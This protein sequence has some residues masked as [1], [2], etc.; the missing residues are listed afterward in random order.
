MDSIDADQVVATVDSP[1][2]RVIRARMQAIFDAKLREL[3]TAGNV[4]NVR[5]FLDGVER[6]ID[7]PQAIQREA[8]K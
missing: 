5:G 2:Y 3:R 6:C 8:E 4:E 7:I 1:G